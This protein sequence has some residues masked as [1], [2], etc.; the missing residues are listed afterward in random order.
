MRNAAA[1]QVAGYDALY[2]EEEQ[3]QNTATR[4]L[5]RS[6]RELQKGVT[7]RGVMKRIG[8][9]SKLIIRVHSEHPA[10]NFPSM[11]LSV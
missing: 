2:S 1:H 6:N 8:K 5:K 9:A 7:V 10:M 11:I 4:C 3:E